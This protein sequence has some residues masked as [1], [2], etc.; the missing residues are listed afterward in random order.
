VG[1][2]QE[3]GQFFSWSG[4]VRILDRH[5]IAI[6]LAPGAYKLAACDP[7]RLGKLRREIVRRLSKRTRTRLRMTLTDEGLKMAI[8]SEM[9]GY[10]DKK[11]TG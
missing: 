5:Y 4:P 11:S 7:P 1:P 9:L 8:D 3:W 10:H 2:D 6:G